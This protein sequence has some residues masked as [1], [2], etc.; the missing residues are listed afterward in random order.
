MEYIIASSTHIRIYDFPLNVLWRFLVS[1]SLLHTFYS[2][3]SSYPFEQFSFYKHF[4]NFSND[5]NTTSTISPNFNKIVV[6]IELVCNNFSASFFFNNIN[7]PVF[8][9]LFALPCNYSMVWMN[10]DFW[11]CSCITY[12]ITISTHINFIRCLPNLSCYHSLPH[13]FA[14]TTFIDF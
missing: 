1:L 12:F 8:P 7:T 10:M 14:I 3:Y 4:L 6:R 2:Y 11:L 13:I 5:I 9:L